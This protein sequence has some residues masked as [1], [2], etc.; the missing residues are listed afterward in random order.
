MAKYLPN[1]VVEHAGFSGWARA[2]LQ[3]DESMG[4]ESIRDLRAMDK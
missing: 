3:M 2:L 1:K 4:R